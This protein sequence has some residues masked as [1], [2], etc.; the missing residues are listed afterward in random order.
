MGIGVGCKAR[1]DAWQETTTI[2]HDHD[3]DHDHDDDD[4]DDHDD[5]NLDDPDDPDDLTL[6]LLKSFS[7]LLFPLKSAFRASPRTP[8]PR[9]AIGSW[10]WLALCFLK[11][12]RTW[13][14]G[15][16]LQGL[17]TSPINNGKKWLNL[18]MPT[19]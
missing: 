2:D 15:L 10:G 16:R 6:K 5:D 8:C 9:A 7:F 3:H 19:K 14:S 11:G 17:L 13:G 1:T 12:S 18:F 4:L